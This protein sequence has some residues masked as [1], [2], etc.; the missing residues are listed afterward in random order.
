VRLIVL[1]VM[2]GSGIFSLVGCKSAAP[3]KK[4]A[5]CPLPDSATL[6]VGLNSQELN[7]WCWAASGQMVM[8]SLGQDVSQCSQANDEFQLTSCCPSAVAGDDC[9]QSGWPEFA[10]HQIRFQRT[11]GTPLSFVELQKQIACRK[12]PVAFS[13]RWVGGGGHMMVAIGYAVIDGTRY[14]EVN[15]PW[16][17]NRGSHYFITYEEYSDAPNNH[18]HWDDFFEFGT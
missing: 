4:T 18:K 14:V 10:K 11:S 9:D 13:W 12:R 7:N 5:E 3:G 6:A 2:L 17:P 1:V 15:D 16:K 8:K